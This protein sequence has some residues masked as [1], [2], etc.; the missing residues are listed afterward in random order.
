[1]S[2]E[3]PIAER[4]AAVMA[5]VGRVERDARNAHANYDYASADAVYD[6]V[7]PL[8]APSMDWLCGSSAHR[9]SMERWMVWCTC[10]C[11]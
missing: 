9:W 8:L 5:E 6:A 4:I 3:R 2:E 10:A 7:R 11:G 1:M